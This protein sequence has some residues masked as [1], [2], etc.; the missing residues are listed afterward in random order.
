MLTNS[1]TILFSLVPCLTSI[2]AFAGT[3]DWIE[4]GPNRLR[5]VVAE[6]QT[7]ESTVRA[8]LDIDLAPGWKTYW[9]DPGDAGVPL[10]L[11]LDGSDNASNPVLNFP[12]PKRFNDGVTIWAG[13]DQPVQIPV[14]F[15]RPANEK[16]GQLETSVFL[17]ICEKICIPVEAKFTVPFGTEPAN[18]AETFLVDQAF[19]RLPAAADGQNGITDAKLKDKQVQITTTMDGAAPSDLYLAAPKGWQFAAPVVLQTDGQQ[20]IFNVKVLYQSD[21]AANGPLNVGYTLTNGET[22]VSGSAEIAPQ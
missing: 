15:T 12:L 13:Y 22:S 7:G 18:T 11:S 19:K 2:P 20:T 8:V 16:S 17:G 3:S 6:P 1:L 5:M 10:H 21:K 14:T 9:Q 4:N